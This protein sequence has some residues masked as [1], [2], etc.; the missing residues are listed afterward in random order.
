MS[1]SAPITS[2]TVVAV[3]SPGDAATGAA[4]GDVVDTVTGGSTCSVEGDVV[5]V[6]RVVA[7][8][9]VVG[10]GGTVG[11]DGVLDVVV[12]PAAILLPLV[13]RARE[14]RSAADGS[15][16]QRCAVAR[17]AAPPHAGRHQVT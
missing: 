12:G 4:G 8:V 7:V 1:S 13:D 2:Q 10:K 9:V 14:R 6:G 16:Q 3:L 5:V 11:N 15:P 17:A